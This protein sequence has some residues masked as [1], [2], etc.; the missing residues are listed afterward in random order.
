MT[1]DQEA[2]LRGK[3]S[4]QHVLE[5][6]TGEGKVTRVLADG[7]TY[8]A[9]FDSSEECRVDTWPGLPTNVTPFDRRYEALVQGGRGFGLL[10]FSQPATLADVREAQ[11]QEA[12]GA[13]W[14]FLHEPPPALFMRREQRMGLWLCHMSNPT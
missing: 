14:V 2:L 7:A 8:V 11:P 5:V 13:L 3:A 1:S 12:P 10:V 6:G 4:G 9:T